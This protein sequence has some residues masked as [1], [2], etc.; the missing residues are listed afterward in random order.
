[1][2]LLLSIIF[3]G[4]SKEEPME[5]NSGEIVHDFEE[6]KCPCTVV[7]YGIQTGHTIGILHSCGSAVHKRSPSFNPDDRIQLHQQLEVF[8]RKDDQD[9]PFAAEG[10]SGSLV[11]LLSHTDNKT[12]IRA[13][14]LLVGGTN[15]GSGIVTPIWA[16]LKKLG[17]PQ[18]LMSFHDKG[19]KSKSA[20]NDNERLRKI[21]SDVAAQNVD[22]TTIKVNLKQ[23]IENTEHRFEVIENKIDDQTNHIDS[24]LK[25]I[26]NAM[27]SK[28]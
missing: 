22:I 1:M 23:S 17:L 9:Q 24:Q 5:F 6:I 27:Q 11:F 26:L 19:A 21:E 28:Q 14:G 20:N 16:V 10:D 12:N 3:I 13:L 4:F 18:Q 2:C 25:E 15:Y 8:A 7:K